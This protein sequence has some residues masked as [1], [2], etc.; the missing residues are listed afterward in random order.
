MS[1]HHIISDSD[2]ENIYDINDVSSYET[3]INCIDVSSKSAR[4]DIFSSTGDRINEIDIYREYHENYDLRGTKER[5][6]GK[7]ALHQIFFLK[8][9]YQQLGLT[10]SFFW[11]EI[12]IYRDNGFKQIHL[13]ATKDG[14]L[15]W[16][17]LGY[18][19]LDENT[20]VN[21]NQ[22]KSSKIV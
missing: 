2:I 11:K 12:N 15:V 4:I 6:F 19:Y 13:E 3:D 18:K 21:L 16:R 20:E 9:E 5:E 22:N 10:T 14:I 8:E 17:S 1:C 7:V